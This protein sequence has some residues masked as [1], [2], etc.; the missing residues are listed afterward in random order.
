MTAVAGVPPDYFS[1]TGQLW[2]MPVFDWKANR[3]KKY[4]WWI[5]RLSPTCIFLTSS[6]WTISERSPLT[7]SAC[8]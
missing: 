4:R 8:R 2:G 6:V 3:R 1:A 5:Q 7:G